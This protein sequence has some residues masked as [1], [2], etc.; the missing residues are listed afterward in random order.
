MLKKK[1]QIQSLLIPHTITFLFFFFSFFFLIFYTVPFHSFLI[2]VKSLAYI[3]HKFLCN[4]SNK[5]N[6]CIHSILQELIDCI[7]ATKLINAYLLDISKKKIRAAL[8]AF[9]RYYDS[10]WLTDIEKFPRPDTHFAK[11]TANFQIMDSF[12]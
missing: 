7:A 8:F 1:V 6:S 3:I 2:E 11:I 4:T 10:F 12:F 5:K 9:S